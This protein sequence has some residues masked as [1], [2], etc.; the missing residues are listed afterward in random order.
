MK[1]KTSAKSSRQ[2]GFPPTDG[3]KLRLPK[4]DLAQSVAQSPVG[5]IETV[6]F[7]FRR[8]RQR[9]DMGDD[10]GDSLMHFSSLKNQISTYKVRRGVRQIANLSRIYVER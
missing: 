1:Y 9:R 8:V 7:S 5:L 4:A 2:R 3:I 6:L 10:G